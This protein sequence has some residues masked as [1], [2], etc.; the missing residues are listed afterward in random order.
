MNGGLKDVAV[1][2]VDLS[3][4]REPIQPKQPADRC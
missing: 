4:E 3:G 1:N 2:K